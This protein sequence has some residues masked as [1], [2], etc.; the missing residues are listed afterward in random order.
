M[1]WSD[2][3]NA[4]FSTASADELVRPVL[5][6]GPHSYER[7]NVTDQRRGPESLLVWFERM[8]HT[9]SECAEIGVGDHQ[10]LPVEPKHVFAHRVQA[11][12]GV[13]VFVHNLADQP[14]R[15]CL[16]E[17]PDEDNQP[18]EVFSDREYDDPDLRD[19]EVDGYGYRWIRLRRTHSRW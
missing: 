11:P 7:V 5:N 8:L 16:P 10:V 6:D 4:G 1:Q 13:V 3:N 2:T 18:V 17:Q 12:N 14:A 19:L 15:V 9:R